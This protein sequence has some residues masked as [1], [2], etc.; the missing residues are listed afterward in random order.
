MNEATT[1]WMTNKEAAEYMG[2]KPY[3]L[4]R[5][6]KDDRLSGKKPPMH[7]VVGASIRYKQSDLDAW[8]TGGSDEA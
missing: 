8:L 6:R 2:Y 5:A 1:R 3:T 4:K 7:Y